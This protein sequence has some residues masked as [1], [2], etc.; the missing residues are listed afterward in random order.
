MRIPTYDAKYWA[1]AGYSG[2]RAVTVNST[3]DQQRVSRSKFLPLYEK[4]AH[5]NRAAVHI[6]EFS[7]KKHQ[8]TGQ[9]QIG[10]F[11]LFCLILN[12][13]LASCILILNDPVDRH[14]IH[15]LF[16]E[17]KRTS[18]RLLDVAV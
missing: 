5:R 9:L 16:D 6:L 8:K 10:V 17:V 2:S 4:K 13:I 7:R 18:C 14:E 3:S 1:N 15:K 12:F 11:C